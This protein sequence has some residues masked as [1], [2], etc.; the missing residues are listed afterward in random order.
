MWVETMLFP[1]A[2][3]LC[4]TEGE[5]IAPE[6]IR[7]RIV[8]RAGIRAVLDRHAPFE[9]EDADDGA[10]SRYTFL[11]PEGSGHGGVGRLVWGTVRIDGDELIAE[12]MAATRSLRLRMGRAAGRW[13]AG[14]YRG[15]TQYAAK[16]ESRF[17]AG[18]AGHRA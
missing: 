11:G 8:D 3:Q 1:L 6:R 10:E 2:P 5:P 14:F 18:T 12:V 9:R 13:R 4:T 16:R 15:R 17:V 7:C